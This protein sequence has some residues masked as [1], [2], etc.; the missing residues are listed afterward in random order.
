MDRDKG[1][2][3]GADEIK[4]L[5]DMLGMRVS[6]P[7]VVPQKYEAINFIY[8]ISYISYIIVCKIETHAHAS[9]LSCELPAF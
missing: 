9:L 5:M 2:T 3:L 1:G 7:W 4:Q 8:Y 6:G